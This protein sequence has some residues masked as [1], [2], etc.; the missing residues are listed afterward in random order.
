MTNKHLCDGHEFPLGRV[1]LEL[2]DCGMYTWT[3][4]G[5]ELDAADGLAIAFGGFDLIGTLPL[6]NGPAGET[7]V[8]RVP[9]RY[10]GRLKAFTSGK[11]TEVHPQLFAS[12]DG[13]SLLLCPVDE[14][15]TRNLV[16]QR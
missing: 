10:R 13:T 15:L 7:L 6:V 3:E 9:R 16:A 12:Q 1:S 5:E 4:N 14:T 2:C 8:Y 11:W